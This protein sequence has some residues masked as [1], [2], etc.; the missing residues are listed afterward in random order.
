MPQDIERFFSLSLD[1]LCIA[2]VD[3]FF[4][5]VNPAFERVLG[6]T[7][8]Q[9]LSRPFVEW[10]H[11]GDVSGTLAE[12]EKLA[13]GVPTV[14]FENRY[15]CAD[16]DYKTLSWNAYPEPETG[17][18]FAVARN[19]TEIRQAE[20]RFRIALQASPSGMLVVDT[21]GFIAFANRAAEDLL[22]Y[23]AGELQGKLVDSLLPADIRA[24]HS[25]HRRGYLSEP[26]ARPMGQGRDLHA[27]KKDGTPVQVEIGLNPVKV[28]GDLALLIAIVDITA[29]KELETVLR[30]SRD[31]LLAIL[32]V[33][34]EG[35]LIIDG[36]G[37][38]AFVNQAAA[39]L[40]GIEP[41]AGTGRPW[42][43]VVMIEGADKAVFEDLLE[44]PSAA[45]GRTRVQIASPDGSRHFV[46]LEVQGH[47]Q[48]HQ[49]K[50][51]FLNDITEILDLRSLRDEQV[52]FHDIVGHTDAMQLVFDQIKQVAPLDWTV[53]VR[54][55]TGTGKELIARAIH[56]QS[57]RKSGPFVPVNCAALSESLLTSQ[58]FG[59]R[60]GA[61]TGAVSDQ[62]GVFEAANGGTIFLDEIGDM[63]LP[64]QSS[65]LRVLQ[66]RE[67]TRLGES[68]PR[69]V[70]VRVIAATHC[71]LKSKVEQGSFRSDLFYRIQGFRITL[72]PLRE[73]PADIPRLVY[74]HLQRAGTLA[75]KAPPPVSREALRSLMSYPWP[76]NVRELRSAIEWAAMRCAGVV[77]IED[78]PPEIVSSVSHADLAKPPP[79]EEATRILRAIKDS[80][81]NRS[82]AARRLGISRATLYRR[83][84]EFG[85]ASNHK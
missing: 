59:H 32:N 75:G 77:Q 80:G 1:M 49:Q 3:G 72:P 29:R 45:E 69:K 8:Q 30:R 64:I 31:D 81:G 48:V 43:E 78:L 46:E 39:T 60:R 15:R 10:V 5:R 18:I 58:L 26:V 44:V 83:L 16:G 76:G 37:R 13:S 79:E 11:P 27:V 9:L 52:T 14:S 85:L 6:W 7:A 82:E 40:F 63:A 23:A 21:G 51:V 35:A 12:I 38:I 62:K 71:D 41:D 70:D 73:R 36:A 67:I 2:S 74:H 50:I 22:G 55:E 61:F 33:L 68:Q 84:A 25:Q 28:N 54:G 24:L 53:L 66:E 4:K 56:F 19:V 65:L 20:E 47:P 17:L 42:N 34:S 57:P